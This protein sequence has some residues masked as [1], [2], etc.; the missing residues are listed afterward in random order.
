MTDL[1][2]PGSP[3]AVKLGCSCPVTGN[4]HGEGV[5]TRDYGQLFWTTPNCKLHGHKEFT[6]DNPKPI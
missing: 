5:W 2:S 1:P 4:H 6:Y 3:E